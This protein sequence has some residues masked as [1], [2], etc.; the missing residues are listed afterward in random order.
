M[1]I[2]GAWS[3]RTLNW[4]WSCCLRTQK[5]INHGDS[6][7]RITANVNF[8]SCCNIMGNVFGS[9]LYFKQSWELNFIVEYPTSWLGDGKLPRYT[10]ACIEN[11]LHKIIW[12]RNIYR[13]N[14]SKNWLWCLK[15]LIHLLLKLK[16]IFN[17]FIT[18]YVKRW[19]V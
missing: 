9:T 3:R 16:K 12:K 8:F 18:A 4:I 6:L 10:Q 15:I 1:Y 19:A 14:Q 13:L 5:V 7:F 17:N 2:F 11:K